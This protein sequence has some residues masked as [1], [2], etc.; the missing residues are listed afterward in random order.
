MKNKLKFGCVIGWVNILELLLTLIHQ[1][2]QKRAERM[3][4]GIYIQGH[5]HGFNVA[6]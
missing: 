4:E 6:A 1:K 3:S 5:K 2:G